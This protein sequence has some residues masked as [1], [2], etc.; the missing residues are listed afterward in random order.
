MNIYVTLPE[1][2]IG[3]EKF[4]QEAID[5]IERI[6]TV[7]W[8]DTG[9]KLSPDELR[10]RLDGVEIL[11]TRWTGCPE[12]TDEILS[13]ATDLELVVHVGGSVGSIVTDAVYDRDI[14]VSSGVRVMALFVAEATLAHILSGLRTIPQ[15]NDELARGEYE[16]DIE[17]LATLFDANVGLVGLGSV[18][19][20]LLPLLKP[21][22][23]DVSVYDPYVSPDDLM[24]YDFATKAS[25]DRTLEG[26]DVVSVHAA[27]TE[28]TLH[29]LDEERL[30]CLKDDA[31]LVNT[32][33]GAIIDEA[34]LIRELRSGRISA[35]LDV[36]ETEPLPEDSELRTLENAVL[37]PH[38]AGSPEGRR[39]ALAMVDE[40][41]R[42]MTGEPLAHELSRERARR[43][44]KSWLSA[45][46][47]DN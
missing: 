35:S 37:T 38:V 10:E 4:P 5:H 47:A 46:D 9:G 7:T 14:Q 42:Y 39:M 17:R 15:F 40:I 34:A 23:V 26:A 20:A 27:K 22:D 44:T 43:M 45:A 11:V 8:N 6:G 18:G 33:R 24:A 36:F 25:L 32:A 3:S 19:R 21:F 28:E 29:L 2:D 30:G 16:R 12:L 31:L 13:E 1:G 41:E